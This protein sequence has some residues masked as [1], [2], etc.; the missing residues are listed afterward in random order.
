[1]SDLVYHLYNP[2]LRHGEHCPL[3]LRWK[4]SVALFITW[5]VAIMKRV[6]GRVHPCLTPCFHF[7][8][9][10]TLVCTTSETGIEAFDFCCEMDWYSSQ[11]FPHAFSVHAIKSFEESIKVPLPFW[12][13]VCY[14]SWPEY[15]VHT[16]PHMS[17]SFLLIWLC[18][19]Q[20]QNN[21]K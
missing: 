4:T 20:F 19:L 11:Y 13:F 7:K 5:S 6:A 8:V 10:M 16:S 18:S 15:M 21:K 2:I 12:L 9:Y 3:M 1:M 14:F 17:K